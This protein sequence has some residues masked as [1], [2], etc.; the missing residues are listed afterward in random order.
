LNDLA[1]RTTDLDPLDKKE[2]SS[3]KGHLAMPLNPSVKKITVHVIL[4]LLFDYVLA[5]FLTL[6]MFC[7]MEERPCSLTY[8]TWIQILWIY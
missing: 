4:L 5:I 7:Q 1:R 8:V 2:A 3:S 6:H